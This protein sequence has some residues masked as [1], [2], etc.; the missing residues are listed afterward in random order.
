MPKGPVY[1]LVELSPYVGQLGVLSDYRRADAGTGFGVV[2]GYRKPMRNARALGFEVAYG[3]SGH[4]NES[5]RT[6]A[7]ATRLVAAARLSM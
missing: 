3:R 4:R 6:D 1:A 5:A 2:V 7:V